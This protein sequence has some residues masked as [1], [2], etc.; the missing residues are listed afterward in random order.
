M[1]HFGGAI[2]SDGELLLLEEPESSSVFLF[3]LRDPTPIH[4]TTF[5]G[6][7]P[8]PDRFGRISALFVDAST[9]RALVADVG[10]RRLGEFHLARDRSAPLRLDPFLAT[11]RRSW[12]LV[13]WSDRVRAL[14]G[15]AFDGVLEPVGFVRRDGA[16]WTIDRRHGLLVELDEQLAPKRAVATGLVGAAGLALVGDGPTARFATTLP[17]EGTVVL[18]DDAGTLLARATG[19]TTDGDLGFVRPNAVARMPDGSLVVTDAGRDAVFVVGADLAVTRRIGQRGASDGDLW[20]PQGVLPY[21]GAPTMHS[22]EDGVPSPVAGPRFVVVDRG[23]HR[24]QI[25]QPDGA[26]L[27]TFGLG[28]SYTR[29]RERGAT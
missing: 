24:A 11:L 8:G 20:M 16:L 4:V 26:W 22:D 27:M 25:F 18:V 2:A 10:H 29:P 1:S 19:R 15:A 5:G 3:D 13:A 17:D 12:D 23:N 6:A 9:Q 28:R 21:A 7:G 14:V